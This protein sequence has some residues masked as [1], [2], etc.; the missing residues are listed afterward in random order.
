[1]QHCCSWGFGIKLY[2]LLIIRLIGT[3]EGHVDVL[4]CF[5]KSKKK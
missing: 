1:M 2:L 4:K 5:V 3:K